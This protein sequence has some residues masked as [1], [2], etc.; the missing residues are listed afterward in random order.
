MSKVMVL[1]AGGWLGR[2]VV[3]RFRS[4]GR[5][6]IEVDTKLPPG[7]GGVQADIRD[8]ERLSS[9][10]KN[11]DMV[12]NCCGAQHPKKARD[13]SEINS[14]AP[15][16][17]YK[18]CGARVFI[19]ISSVMAYGENHANAFPF[20]ESSKERPITP[21]GKSKLAGD[22][23]LIGQLNKTKLIILRPGVF[24]G[25]SPSNNLIEFLAKLKSSPM[26]IF[27]KF[28]MLRTYVDIQ[29]VVDA[30]V[31]SEN[32]GTSGSAYLIGDI[33]PLST[34]RFYEVLAEE[35]KCTPKIVR[36]PQMMSRL[37][38][39]AAIKASDAG[40][41]LRICNIIG[42]FGRH[43]HFSSQRAVAELGFAP[44]ASSEPGLR[45]MARAAGS[46]P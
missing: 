9:H 45:E 38:E 25:S 26:P 42:E 11:C 33:Q 4:S 13:L 44:H 46:L 41:H 5:D 12:V 8:I 23:A 17:V 28:G 27:S 36:V 37:S 3:D 16:E 6:V 20:D 1:G 39:F 18:A 22:A 32:R 15:K 21:Y 35:M 14:I 29:K 2:T 24:Y 30:I 34:K 10:F 43:V 40:F 19:H 31:L 7:S